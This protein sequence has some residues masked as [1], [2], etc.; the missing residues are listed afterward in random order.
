MAL[1]FSSAGYQV[2][3]EAKDLQASTESCLDKGAGILTLWNAEEENLLRAELLKMQLHNV[4]YWRGEAIFSASRVACHEH[5][6]FEW[7]S[8]V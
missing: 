5:K 7:K 3:K 2:N 4:F 1:A 8:C 6:P